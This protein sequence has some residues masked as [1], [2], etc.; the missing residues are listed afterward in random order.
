MKKQYTRRVAMLGVLCTGL[1]TAGF[2]QVRPYGDSR[3]F[4]PVPSPGI[5]KESP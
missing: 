5:P 1:G 2:A 3:V 4:A